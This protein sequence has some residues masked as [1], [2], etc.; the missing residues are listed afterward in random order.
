MEARRDS[1]SDPFFSICIPQFNRTSFLIETLKSLEAQE[2]RSF[3][4]CISDDC[5]TDGREREILEFLAAS[6]LSYT[7]RRRDTN[8][9]YDKNLRSAIALA[10]GQFCLLLGN[11][12]QLP[13]PTALGDYRAA[14]VANL[15]VGVATCNFADTESGETTRRV[16]A[17]QRLDGGPHTAA[18]VYRN[19]SV[20]SGVVL[21]R[22]RA[23]AHATDRWDGGEMYQ[24]YIG[25]RI[26][27]EGYA[28]L[29]VDQVLIQLGTV[30]PGESVDSVLR[31]QRV[32][33][34]PI[35]ERQITLTQM[36]R[37]IADA[38][39]PYAPKHVWQRHAEWIVAQL[40]L[41]PYP[42]WLVTFRRV[43]SWRYALGIALGM[44][45]RNVTAGI[46]LPLMGRLRLGLLYVAISLGGLLV[47]D[48]LFERARR[49]LLRLAKLFA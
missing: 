5:S 42:Y 10:R 49:P 13:S 33:P 39:V 25:S 32:D 43:Q 44:R 21:E 18:R 29:Y 46:D 6:N 9:R 38:I 27:A 15:P 22:S 48:G 24:T 35:V 45:P 41:F 36:A 11:D 16:R 20:V 34:C 37:I 14:L 1:V 31:R 17:T 40:Y 30:I 2:Y 23:H 3:E 12:D 26:I 19:F 8:G 47:P 7:Y 28:V 4:V